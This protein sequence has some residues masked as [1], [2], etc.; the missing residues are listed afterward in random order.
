MGLMVKAEID[1][2]LQT[3]ILMQEYVN[4]SERFL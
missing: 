3:P 2:N 1:W 4:A